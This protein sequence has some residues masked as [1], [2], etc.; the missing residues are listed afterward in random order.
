MNQ[1]DDLRRLM[2]LH[3]LVALEADMARNELAI[4]QQVQ[5]ERRRGRRRDR[6]YWTRA[7]PLSR[8][9][10]GQYE[11]LMVELREEDVPA[12]KNFVRME[13]RMFQE[14]LTRL[15]ERIEKK[16]TWYRKAIPPGLKLAITIRYLATG[17]SYHSLMYNFRVAHNTISLIVRDVCEAIISEFA[18]EASHSLSRCTRRVATGS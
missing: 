11:R 13:P 8:P 12:F 9:L 3:D 16:D 17:A 5:E 18:E 14:V 4:A 2:L 6:R 7:W 10:L 15:G 1:G